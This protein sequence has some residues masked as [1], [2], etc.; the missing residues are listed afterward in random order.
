MAE[1]KGTILPDW[2]EDVYFDV[3]RSKVARSLFPS[4]SD[5]ATAASL[6][7]S[8]T[9]GKSIPGMMTGAVLETTGIPGIGY[10][11]SRM[12]EMP[13]ARTVDQ[14]MPIERMV[15]KPETFN[16][17]HG[18]SNMDDL[19][20][21]QPRTQASSN[22]FTDGFYGTGNKFMSAQYGS[23]APGGGVGLMT[24]RMNRPFDFNKKFSKEEMMSMLK[25]VDSPTAKNTLRDISKLDDNVKIDGESFLTYMKYSEDPTPGGLFNRNQAATNLLDDLGFD[26]VVVGREGMNDIQI[27]LQ[28]EKQLSPGWTGMFQP[29]KVRY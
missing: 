18:T 29:G 23:I 20:R 28:T 17:Y 9:E 8:Q 4:A 7:W 19:V 21:L 14:F 25:S 22:V 26:G 10:I 1:A 13:I 27:F 6:G 16:I 5:L 24:G 12:A 11:G 3:V 15:R 2:L